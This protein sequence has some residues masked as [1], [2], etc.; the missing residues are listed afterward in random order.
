MKTSNCP[1]YYEGL[2]WSSRQQYAAWFRTQ[3]NANQSPE[4]EHLKLQLSGGAK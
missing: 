3:I 2:Y 1:F 4:A